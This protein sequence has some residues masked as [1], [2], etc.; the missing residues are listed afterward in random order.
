MAK[1]E[2][3]E[4]PE[5]CTLN[6]AD[7]P[8]LHAEIQR[9]AERLRGVAVHTPLLRSAALDARLGARVLIKAENLQHAGSFKFRGACN[10]LSQ[11]AGAERAAGVVAWS[12][13]N[14][15]QGVA[16]AARLLGMPAVIVMPADAPAVKIANTRALGAEIR[17]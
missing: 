5:R 1:G 10:R 15:A 14:H 3:P 6:L 9:A 7:I 8:A 12:S 4:R 2:N 13:G 11:L 16:L 17:F